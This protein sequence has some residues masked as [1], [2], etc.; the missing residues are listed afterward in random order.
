M[1]IFFV[2]LGYLRLRPLKYKENNK[3]LCDIVLIIPSEIWAGW[4]S[5]GIVLYLAMVSI[6]WNKKK[7][8]LTRF[9]TKLFF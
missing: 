8:R 2:S 3:K 5:V 9:E 4:H 1:I 6:L 7:W